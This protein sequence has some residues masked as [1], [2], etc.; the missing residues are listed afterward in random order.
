MDG[1]P[2]G[3]EKMKNK[4][5]AI[6]IAL[7]ATLLVSAFSVAVVSAFPTYYCNDTWGTTWGNECV[8]N[9]EYIKGDTNDGNYACMT[10][11]DSEDPAIIGCYFN[12]YWVGGDI[13]FHTYTS[14]TVHVSIYITNDGIQWENIADGDFSSS[15]VVDVPVYS[16]WTFH[17]MEVI[18][19][20]VD[21][22]A[23]IYIDSVLI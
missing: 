21:G 13:I 1:K 14:G 9:I 22:P 16:I 4:K 8:D 15:S 3:K 20:Y 5:M 10:V 2:L 12:E 11:E 6:S 17:Y 19:S 23:S 18:I 7:L